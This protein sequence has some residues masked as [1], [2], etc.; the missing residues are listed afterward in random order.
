MPNTPLNPR[1]APRQA[2]AQAT[3]DAILEAATQ[4]LSARGLNGFNTNA[5]AARAGTSIGSLYQYFPNK[6]ALMLALIHRQKVGMFDAVSRAMANV[7]QRDLV[8]SVRIFIRAVME[9]IRDD[10]LLAMAIDHEE[11]R[12]PIGHVIDGYMQQC[13]VMLMQLFQD[14]GSEIQGLDYC[15][16]ARTLPVI[17]RAVIDEWSNGTPAHLDIAEEEAVCAMLGYLARQK[18]AG[19]RDE[20]DVK[21][22]AAKSEPAAGGS[23]RKRRMVA[24]PATVR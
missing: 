18:Q 8:T 24:R 1:K 11:A 14:C 16:A 17:I 23:G 2:R 4:I 5:V 19:P 7:T 3:H 12:L 6:D 9:H 10:S 20:S 13:S 15:R 22:V 21:R